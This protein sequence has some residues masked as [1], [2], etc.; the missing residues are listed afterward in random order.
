MGTNKDS[1]GEA[2][3]GSE[4]TGEDS[5]E[6]KHLLQSAGALPQQGARTGS[7]KTARRRPRLGGQGGKG[8]AAWPGAHFLT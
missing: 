8:K 7:S 2:P 4:I 5:S 3:R 1:R 6:D